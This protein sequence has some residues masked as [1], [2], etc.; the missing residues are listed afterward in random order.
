[1]TAD[2]SMRAAVEQIARSIQ[3]PVVDPSGIR[4]RSRRTSRRWAVIGSSVAAALLIGVTSGV[5]FA[6]DRD[7]GPSPASPS[8][9]RTSKAPG[10]ANPAGAIWYGEGVLHD[11]QQS[12]RVT[13][14]MATNLAIVSGGVLYGDGSGR[15][16]YQ[17]QDGSTAVIAKNSRL[18][19]SGDPTSDVVVWF[20]DTAGG[21]ELVV[22]DVGRSVELGRER[23]GA[24][25][26]RPP[27]SMVG[28]LQP[29]VLW[30]GDGEVAQAGVYFMAD[31][32]LW[33]YDWTSGDPARPVTGE[34]ARVLDVGGNVAAV[35]G[36]GDRSITF[37]SLQGQV[38]STAS[39]EP[40]GA[41]SHD[42][43]Y[44]VGY[45][46]EGTVVINTATGEVRP[47]DLDP[48]SVVMGIT[49][50]RDNTVVMLQP[51]LGGDGKGSVVA[52]DAVSLR[53]Q[54]GKQVDKVFEIALPTLPGQ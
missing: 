49:W 23:L 25:D 40:D 30:V 35:A 8:P 12:F 1:M 54:S 53:C 27:E 32:G 52:C 37:K 45:A 36:P 18:G 11:D 19:P 20:E 33:R 51:E 43:R 41:F 48:Y 15:V 16:I 13:G 39:V 47:L 2:E 9:T 4:A 24:L 5:W 10:Q 44:Y 26:V 34:L 6:I 28:R 14:E 21:V 17:R 31:G 38:L 29:P 42:G 7:A 3:P 46:A 50:A 22:Y